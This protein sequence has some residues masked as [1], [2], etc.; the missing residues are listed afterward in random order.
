MS[1][2]ISSSLSLSYLYVL[3]TFFTYAFPFPCLSYHHSSLLSDLPFFHVEALFS[4]F[5]FFFIPP[6]SHIPFLFLS[7]NYSLVISVTIPSQQQ[8]KV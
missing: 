6:F 5:C 7:S 8:K 4:P 2:A 3:P 1:N